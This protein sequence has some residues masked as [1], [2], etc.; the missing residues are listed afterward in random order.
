[1]KYKCLEVSAQG[2]PEMLKV[3]EKDLRDPEAGEVRIKVLAS[4][5]CGPDIQARYGQTP[6]APKTPF[7]RV[8][9]SS[10]Q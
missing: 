4:P 7:V 9:L 2:G 8:M 1:M 5:V 3:V 6:I 10:A